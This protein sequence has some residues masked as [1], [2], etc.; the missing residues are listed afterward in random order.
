MLPEEVILFA[1]QGCDGSLCVKMTEIDVKHNLDD[2]YLDW[3]TKKRLT[4]KC[5]FNTLMYILMKNTD[6]WLPYTTVRFLISERVNTAKFEGL[7]QGHWH[8]FQSHG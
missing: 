1:I 4:I 2:N 3:F 8:N 6:T 5:I 7:H